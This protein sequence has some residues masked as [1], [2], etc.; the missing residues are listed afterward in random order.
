[1]PI[2]FSKMPEVGEMEWKKRGFRL[3]GGCVKKLGNWIVKIEPNYR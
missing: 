1:M 2:H 3:K